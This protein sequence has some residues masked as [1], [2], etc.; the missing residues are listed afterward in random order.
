MQN[1]QCPSESQPLDKRHAIQT[2]LFL[3]LVLVHVPTCPAPDLENSPLSASQ[4]VVDETHR[5]LCRE[6]QSIHD[7]GVSTIANGCAPDLLR[8]C[9]SRF[10]GQ[11]RRESDQC[12]ET[13]ARKS[14]ALD[15]APLRCF[16]SGGRA[17]QKSLPI[18]R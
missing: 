4:P 1:L 8:S 2:T 15:R 17:D 3:A 5:L 13:P 14:P 12:F 18:V 16:L 10:A 6:K 9:K 7:A 11:H